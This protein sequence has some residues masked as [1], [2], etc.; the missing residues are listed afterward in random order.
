MTSQ[1]FWPKDAR[2]VLTVSLMFEAGAE[3]WPDSHYLGPLGDI[4]PGYRDLPGETFFEYGYREAIP[5]LLDLFDEHDIKS[6]VFAVG[7][8]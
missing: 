8:A 7:R 4:D 2:L 5:R 1:S 6:T 3:V